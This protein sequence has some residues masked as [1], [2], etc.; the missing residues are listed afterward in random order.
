MWIGVSFLG[1]WKLKGKGTRFTTTI[2]S[3]TLLGKRFISTELSSIEGNLNMYVENSERT[4]LP[5]GYFK[6][7]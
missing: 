1:F 6:I 2:S 4:G 3:L 7:L 5:T